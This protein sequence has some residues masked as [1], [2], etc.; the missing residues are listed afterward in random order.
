RD[1]YPEVLNV[2]NKGLRDHWCPDQNQR[3][4]TASATLLRFSQVESS[5]LNPAQ[6]RAVVNGEKSWIGA[7]ISSGG[8]VIDKS[9]PPP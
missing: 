1:E 2:D 4:Q 8:A 9:L 6:A 5:P 7:F 3:L